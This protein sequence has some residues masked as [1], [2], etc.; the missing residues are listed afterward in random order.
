MV[1]DLIA[2]TQRRVQAAGAATAGDVR[3]AGQALAGFSDELAQEERAL[4][5]FLYAQLY[6]ASEL[7]PVR[8]EAQR[9]V[10]NLAQ[11]YLSEPRLLPDAWCRDCGSETERARNVGDYIAGM[12]DPF[13][14]RRHEELVGPV[15]LPSKF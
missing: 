5:R 12:T 13:A 15:E 6:N 11:A 7:Q 8:R 10:A 9:V 1:G 14:I 4:K 2:E 3:G